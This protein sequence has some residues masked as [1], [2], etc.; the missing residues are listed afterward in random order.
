MG[1]RVDERRAKYY[2]GVGQKYAEVKEHEGLCA[3]G[4]K[5]AGLKG[6]V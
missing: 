6:V 5:K 4:R 2:T 1:G 3:M